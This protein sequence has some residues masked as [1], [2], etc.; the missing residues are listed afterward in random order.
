MSVNAPEAGT[1][2][3]YLVNE[4]DTVTV[5]Q[6]LLK[7]ELG[8]PPAGGDKEQGGQ[9]PKEPAPDKQSTSSDPEPKRDHGTS[10]QKASEPPSPPPKKQPEP[11]VEAEPKKEESKPSPQPKEE[12]SSQEKA[13]KV[14]ESKQPES[15]S[16]G[17]GTPY[18]SR[19]ER[20]VLSLICVVSEWH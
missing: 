9:E 7:L 19:E 1:V 15:K 14:Q 5:G 20:R 3:E 10:D 8:G 13:S 12:L 16:V 11:E 18:G 4:E 17:R 6:D 2:K